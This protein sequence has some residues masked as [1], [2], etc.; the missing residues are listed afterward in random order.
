M[1]LGELLRRIETA[2]NGTPELDSE[3]AS[4]FPSAPTRLRAPLMQ[5]PD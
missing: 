4:V 5:P 1:D 2:P 3:F